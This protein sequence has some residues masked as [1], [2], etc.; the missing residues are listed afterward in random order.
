MTRRTLVSPTTAPL[1]GVFLALIALAGCAPAEPPLARVGNE[2][3]TVADFNAAANANARQYL[4]MG[5]AGKRVLLD[6][7]V[8]RRLLVVA[9][10]QSGFH[11]DTSFLDFVRQTREQLADQM[12]LRD[13]TGGDV[14]VSEPEVHAAYERRRVEARARVIFAPDESAAREAG[15]ELAQGADFADV[16]RRFSSVSALPDGGDLGFVAPG[17]LVPP[18]DDWLLSAPIGKVMGP[19]ESRGQG[20][21][22]MRVEARRPA[23][24]PPYVQVHEQILALLQQR[25]QRAWLVRNAE[26]LKTAYGVR[27]LPG[28]AATFSD[29]VRRSSP[30]PGTNPATPLPPLSP[31]DAAQPLAVWSG[32]TYTLGDAWQALQA[33]GQQPPNST[34]TPLVEHWLENQV[35]SRVLTAEAN[36]RRL[37]EDPDPARVLNERLNNYLL[38]AY[39][40]Q[41][42]LAAIAVSDQDLREAYDRHP[43]AF[44]VLESA[45]MMTLTLPESLTTEQFAMHVGHAANLR[46]AARMVGLSDAVRQITVRYPSSDPMWS[47]FEPRLVTMREGEY[48]GPFPAPGGQLVIQLVSKQQ[49]MPAW[50]QLTAVNRQQL[51]TDVINGKRDA[52]FRAVVD[53][54]RRTIPVSVDSTVVRRLS[55]PMGSFMPGPGQ[56]G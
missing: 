37:L 12:M 15:F 32:G 38:Q 16:A 33:P 4:V 14:A 22:L 54:L 50:D 1:G 2:T 41:K 11:A 20:W 52:R 8:D 43:D 5:D 42:V 49:R 24:L 48:A 53:S 30:Q 17:S 39:Y 40:N 51:Q 6:D 26:W 31:A 13:L 28:S 27:V 3:I 19:V 36:T 55:W 23:E 56:G 34:M 47:A 29:R 7:L 9:A 18:L 44:A 21:F 10:K 25:K 46:E 35:F 45:E